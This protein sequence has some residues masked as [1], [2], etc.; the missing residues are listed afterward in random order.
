MDL[1]ERNQL[2]DKVIL[3]GMIQDRTKLSELF[4]AVDIFV[5]PS[6]REGLPNV[7]LEAMASGLPVIVTPL[8]GLES[9]IENTKTGIIVP[10]EDSAA[11]KSS[12]IHLINNPELGLNLGRS[13]SQYVQKNH[14]F[15]KW[16]SDMKTV[17]E[18][19]INTSH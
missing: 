18:S 8:P 7:V 17:Y 14:S 1:I 16:Q 12:I 13:A 15:T 10:F 11:I 9:V 5:L 3:L 6:R 19:I 4:R 2:K